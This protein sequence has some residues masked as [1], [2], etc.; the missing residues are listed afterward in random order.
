VDHPPGAPDDHMRALLAVLLPF[1]RESIAEHGDFFP[2]GAAML[3]DG[4]LQT[5]PTWEGDDA[6]TAEDVL[7]VVR[8]GLR[9]RA[10]RGELL[11]TGVVAG[12]SI[13]AGAFPLG[14][15]IELE[16]RDGDAVTWVIPYRSDDERYD[17]GEPFTVDGVR[18]TW[19]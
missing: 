18:S 15:R 5:A 3:P 9:A 16:H 12:V 19:G 7:D 10:D 17:E 8:T 14:I 6:P 2:F 11:A 1:A 4:E 13:D